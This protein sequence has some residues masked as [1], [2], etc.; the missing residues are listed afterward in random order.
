VLTG[1]VLKAA[2][3]IVQS[4][5]E[6]EGPMR[7]PNAPVTIDASLDALSGVLDAMAK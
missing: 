3:H 7:L 4:M 2:D 6:K 1:H 5:H